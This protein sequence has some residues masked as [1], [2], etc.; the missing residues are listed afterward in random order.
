MAV[1]NQERE[2]ESRQGDL[3]AWT[4]AFVITLGLHVGIVV[5]T[6]LWVALAIE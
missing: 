1:A 6:T 4:V 5:F 2:P 3:W